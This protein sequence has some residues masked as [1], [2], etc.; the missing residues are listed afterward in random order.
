[1]RGEITLHSIMREQFEQAEE[2]AEKA[3][4]LYVAATRARDRLLVYGNIPTSRKGDRELQTNSQVELWLRALG[5]ELDEHGELT[6][7][8]IDHIPLH[9]LSDEQLV[10][11]HPPSMVGV[12]LDE[13]ELPDTAQPAENVRLHAPPP[14]SRWTLPITAFTSYLADGSVDALRELVWYASSGLEPGEVEGEEGLDAPASSVAQDQARRFAA[15]AGDLLHRSYQAFGP[16]CSWEQAEAMIAA[17]TSGWGR[18]GLDGDE[19]YARLKMLIEAGETLGLKELPSTAKRELPLLMRFGNVTLRGRAD[20]AFVEEDCAVAVDYKTN[21]I[22]PDEVEELV[23]SHG[24]EHQAKLYAIALAKAWKK[25]CAECRL[26]FLGAGKTVTI[27]VGSEDEVFYR[28]KAAGLTADWLS[29][30]RKG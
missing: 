8:K 2:L 5:V 13:I 10:E 14:L 12:S 7:P 18:K 25:P 17:E 30:E 6:E 20:L 1:M 16:G 29:M 26:V 4:L 15:E 11:V 3:R 19:G 9:V 21:A 22:E 23:R 27:T 24:Y 28:E